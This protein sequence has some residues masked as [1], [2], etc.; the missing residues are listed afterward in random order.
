MFGVGCIQERY[1]GLLKTRDPR[2]GSFPPVVLHKLPH[3]KKGLPF[4]FPPLR[5]GGQGG[6]VPAAAYR[7]SL[8][9][10]SP[11]PVHTRTPA[12]TH[13]RIQTLRLAV[14]RNNDA[15]R[16]HSDGHDR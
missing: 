14:R 9:R 1:P 13:T 11:T 16:V 15:R 3:L 10:T 6:S 2:S 4:P 12:R 7:E 8:D 5:R